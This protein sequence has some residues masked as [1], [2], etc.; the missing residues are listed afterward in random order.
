MILGDDQLGLFHTGLINGECSGQQVLVVQA[1]DCSNHM[2]EVALLL[3]VRPL[4]SG[5]ARAC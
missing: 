5:R 4:E 3:S 1:Q 2:N